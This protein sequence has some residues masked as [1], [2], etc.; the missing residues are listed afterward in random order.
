MGRKL[1]VVVPQTLSSLECWF[2]AQ[3]IN[4]TDKSTDSER[5]D[6][7]QRDVKV[8]ENESDDDDDELFV[9]LDVQEQEPLR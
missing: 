8:S 2:C 6:L 9:D 3:A 7:E 1:Q 5:H 4:H